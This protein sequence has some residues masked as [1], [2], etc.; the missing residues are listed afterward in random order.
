MGRRFFL[1]G[2]WRMGR[3]FNF[4]FFFFRETREG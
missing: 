1:L 2:G 4:F 3:G